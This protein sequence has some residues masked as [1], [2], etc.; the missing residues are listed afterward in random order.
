MSPGRRRESE[1]KGTAV[2]ESSDGNAVALF[3]KDSFWESER[4]VATFDFRNGG[5]VK[6][7]GGGDL[8]LR[9]PAVET[10]ETEVGGD[11]DVGRTKDSHGR[12]R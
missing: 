12:R 11:A 2:S 9:E 10:E 7:E 6:G 1:A 8:G 4:T 5:T 3:E